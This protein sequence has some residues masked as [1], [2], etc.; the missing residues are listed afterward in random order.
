MNFCAL[1]NLPQNC[2][3]QAAQFQIPLCTPYEA[4]VV[5]LGS[6]RQKPGVDFCLWDSGDRKDER[7]E[8]SAPSGPPVAPHIPRQTWFARCTPFYF[9]ISLL[10]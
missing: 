6:C 3:S 2:T 1:P 7:C 5:C 4:Q 8:A 10:S 9:S